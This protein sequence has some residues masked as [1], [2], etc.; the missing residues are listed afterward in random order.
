MRC[1]C[2]NEGSLDVLL[3]LGRQP[4]SNRFLSEPTTD[5]FRH[6]MALGCCRRCGLVQI[7][8]APPIEEMRPRYPWITNNEPE[9]H[10]PKLVEMTDRKFKPQFTSTYYTLNPRLSSTTL[11]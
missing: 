2:G 9:G 6:P 3:D 8:D 7:I 11:C 4:L 10:V 1:I 5:E